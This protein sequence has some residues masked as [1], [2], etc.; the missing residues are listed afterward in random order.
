ME[1]ECLKCLQE[2]LSFYLEKKK[3][4]EQKEY[5]QTDVLVSI[6]L[7]GINKHHSLEN[8]FK[9][10]KGKNSPSTRK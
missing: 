2:K 9:K 10:R 1:D 7:G 3:I 5:E 8:S 6:I 4:T